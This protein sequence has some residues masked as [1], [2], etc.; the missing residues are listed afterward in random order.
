M[1]ALTL[2]PAERDIAKAVLAIRQLTEG[3]SNATCGKTASSF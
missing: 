3:R 1:T 2:S